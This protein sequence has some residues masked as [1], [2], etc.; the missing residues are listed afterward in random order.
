[1]LLLLPY[2]AFV[3]AF[4]NPIEIVRRIK[5]HTMRT[6]Q[7]RKPSVGF[8]QEEAVRGVEQLADVALNAMDHKDK[9]ISMAGVDALAAMA[10]DYQAFCD[11]LPPPWF[12]IEAA[13]ALNSDFVSMTPEAIATV[14]DHRVWFEL[15][16]LREYQ[17]I[18]SEALNRVRDVNYLV[19]INSRRLGEIS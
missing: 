12:R 14:T 19:A 1:L 16:I 17:T 15:K 18:Y 13:L 4:L 3:F 5:S 10:I 6:V 9:G 11:D 8:I 2:F 7:S